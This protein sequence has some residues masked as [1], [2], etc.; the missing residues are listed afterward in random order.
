VRVLL[1]RSNPRKDGYTQEFTDLFL[2][3]LSEANAEVV[4]IHLAEKNIGSCLGCYHC[5]LSEPGQCVQ[6]DDMD[7]LLREFI[8]A[9]MVVCATPI[10]YYALS[11]H[12]QKFLERALPLTKAGL[13]KTPSGLFRNKTRHTEGW[14]GKIMVFIAVGALRD[15][16]NFLPLRDTCRLIAEA[17]NMELGGVLIRTES[18]LT[19][20][21]RS[22]PTV[23]K[24]V[25]N[26]FVSAGKVAG[27]TGY[28]P[29]VISDAA[30][31]YISPDAESFQQQSRIYW[32]NVMRMGTEALDPHAAIETVSRDPRLIIYR[33][34]SMVDPHTTARV[35]AV[36]QFDFTDPT[37]HLC[38]TINRGTASVSESASASPT[39]RICCQSDTWAAVAFGELDARKALTQGK[40]ELHGDRSLF[41]R[42][43]R[44]FRIS[45]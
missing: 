32:E 26:A 41:L 11:C 19:R 45:I 28:I 29:K 39:L 7:D 43:P 2:Q 5:W 25:R 35:E 1:L 38:V 9:D 33:M 17:L 3:G 36:I 6:R 42:L 13:D 15:L 31:A 10:Y 21:E 22:N 8:A 30:S 37:S 24:Q 14:E 40:I 34:A 20:F 16:S 12:I 18:H 27:Q 4:D 23:Q 44:L